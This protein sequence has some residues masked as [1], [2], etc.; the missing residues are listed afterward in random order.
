[1]PMG[2]EPEPDVLRRAVERRWTHVVG[3]RHLG[4][5]KVGTDENGLAHTITGVDPDRDHAT[6]VR[7]ERVTMRQSTHRESK[8]RARTHRQAA[9]TRVGCTGKERSRRQRQRDADPHRRTRAPHLMAVHR[10]WGIRQADLTTLLCYSKG[11]MKFVHAADL[12]LDSPL[13][14]LV[15]YEGAP[16]GAI[17]GATRRALTNLID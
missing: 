17:R 16:L 14:G 8:A 7:R 10:G 13:R 5:L 11:E 1:M 15:R 9:L 6:E 4:P 2:F 12:H 3:N